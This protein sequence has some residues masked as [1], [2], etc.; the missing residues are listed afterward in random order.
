VPQVC[1][2]A[3][4]TTRPSTRSRRP[5]PDSPPPLV[6]VLLLSSTSDSRPAR[7]PLPP[8]LRETLARLRNGRLGASAPRSSRPSQV[9]LLLPV[10]TPH[11]VVC[12]PRLFVP[13]PVCL[14][15]RGTWLCPGLLGQ[16]RPQRELLNASRTA[17]A[18]FLLRCSW[19]WHLAFPLFPGL[20]TCCRCY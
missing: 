5:P 4:S 19:C 17:T 2:V 7:F 14:P 18:C 6:S 8:R 12:F 9:G 1:H 15:P 20:L 13:S 10:S 11:V 3:T 16:V